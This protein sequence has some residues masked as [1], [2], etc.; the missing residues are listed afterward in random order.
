MGSEYQ[1]LIPPE[2][3]DY[4]VC[5]VV[6][7]ILRRYDV[8][9]SQREIASR[10]TPAENGHVVD[11]D[12]LKNLFE[13]KGLEY[14]F[15]WNHETPF[16]E[17]DFVLNDMNENSGIVGISSHLYLFDKFVDPDCYLIDPNNNEIVVKRIGELVKEMGSSG[18][19]GVVKRQD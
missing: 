1:R 7:G 16:N 10:L 17:P 8:N 11:D 12:K 15:F 14:N 13:S 19:F 6:Q 4:C 18:F 2:R 5:S 3:K 9:L